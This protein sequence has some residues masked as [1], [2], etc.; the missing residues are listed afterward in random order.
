MSFWRGNGAVAAADLAASPRAP[1]HRAARSY[2]PSSS[3]WPPTAPQTASR[4]AV[5]GRGGEKLPQLADGVVGAGHRMAHGV[6]RHKN[7]VV[8]SALQSK[9]RAQ[10]QLPSL[11]ERQNLAS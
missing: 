11:Q 8:V 5:L 1:L 2:W 10:A 3:P 9:S 7:L 4:A 6:G